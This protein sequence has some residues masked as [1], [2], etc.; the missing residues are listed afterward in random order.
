MR[1][2]AGNILFH[3]CGEVSEICGEELV[4]AKDSL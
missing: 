4:A 1:N 3:S 2:F